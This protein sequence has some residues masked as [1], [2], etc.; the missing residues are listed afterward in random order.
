M[1]YDV[2][3]LC[4]YG[5][6]YLITL[7]RCKFES[8]FTFRLVYGSNHLAPAQTAKCAAE[9]PPCFSAISPHGTLC[10]ILGDQ[11]KVLAN[12]DE[13]ATKNKK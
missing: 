8:H 3:Y 4:L 12:K 11:K 6:W 10:V 2:W 9:V 1:V 5:V 7:V 13:N